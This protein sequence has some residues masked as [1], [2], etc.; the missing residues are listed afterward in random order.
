M[1]A[2]LIY[3]FKVAV[4]VAAL[5][6]GYRLLLG[7]ETFHRFNRLVLITIALLSFVLPLFHI[8]RHPI[9]ADNV[10]AVEENTQ[11]VVSDIDAA[12]AQTS[13]PVNLF[14]ILLVLYGAGVLFVLIKKGISVW[15][16]SRIIRSGRYAD[17]AEGVDVIESDQIPGPLNWMRFIVM[18]HEW[19]ESENASVWKHENLH[20]HRWHSLDL[21]MA[22]IMTAFQWFNPVMILLRKEFELIHEYEA[23]RA[24]IDSGANPKE[25]KLMLVNAVAA[26]RGMAMTSWLKQSN[27]KKRIDMMDKKQS[28]GWRRLRVLFI[29]AI[30]YFFLFATANVAMAE[31]NTFRWPVFEDGKTWIYQ[32]GTCKV[33]TFNGVEASM[34]VSELADYLANY[35]DF[36]TT[37]MTLMYTY[38]IEGLAEVQPLAEQLVAKGIRI[39]V[40]NNDEILT[41]MTMPEYRAARIFDLGG[42]QYRFELNCNLK[43]NNRMADISGDSSYIKY[44]T[45][46][47]T[48]DINLM[49]K[50][51]NLFDGHGVSIYPDKMSA[52]EADELAKTV[53]GRGIEQFSIVTESENNEYI[54]GERFRDVTIIPMNFNIASHY[55]GM[56][57][58]T[59]AKQM[60]SDLTDKY[61]GKGLHIKDP[62]VFFNPEDDWISIN[63]VNA[64]DEFIMVMGMHQHRDQWVTGLSECEIEVN[65]QW[66]KE[67]RNEGMEGFL[68]HYFWSPVTAAYVQTVHFP[69]LPKDVKTINFRE[70]TLN[71]NIKKIQVTEDVSMFENVRSIEV[72]GHT[73]LKTTHLN[74]DVKDEFAADRVDFGENETTVYCLMYIRANHSFPGHIGNDYKLTLANGKVLDAIRIE[75]LPVNEDFDRHGDWVSS[76]Y[77]VIFPAISE[78][79]WDEGIPTLS[80]SVCHEPVSIKLWQPGKPEGITIETVGDII[81]GTY[82][83]EVHT[84]VVEDDGALGFKPLKIVKVTVDEKEKITF[85]GDESGLFPNGKYDLV[86]KHPSEI[87]ELKGTDMAKDPDA[88]D[89][90]VLKIKKNQMIFRVIEE[91]I[92]EDSPYYDNYG[93]INHFYIMSPVRF[94]DKEI[95]NGDIMQMTLSP[96]VE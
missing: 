62:K 63:L 91:I 4:L 37:R 45:P 68:N 86:W 84:A 67:T 10:D 6:G 23:D 69:A 31:D 50:W 40:A 73:Y 36:K 18:P 58:Q 24:V 5:F 29:P 77:Q 89:L 60:L 42:G 57:A 20:A 35:K 41:Q 79:E 47:I 88:P 52:K 46:S 80:G 48:G 66:I 93:G 85:A 38:P 26:S 43:M 17:R 82:S 75:G 53:W 87:K 64:D 83:A 76:P 1:E 94:G 51:I 81:Q 14:A 74:D 19:L 49:K 71:I 33:R 21:L 13:A 59:A 34:K 30:A 12:A 72:N 27:L 44:P 11:L 3:Q 78:E 95:K 61:Y 96:K 7:R 32:D 56:D 39:S 15:T 54:M 70:K 22:D 16:M 92:D 28:N 25:Y 8:T 90:L 65:G 2:L 55:P 9:A